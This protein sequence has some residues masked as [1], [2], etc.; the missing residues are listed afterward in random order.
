MKVTTSTL[1]EITGEELAKALGIK[2]RLA[3]L[4]STKTKDKILFT[5]TCEGETSDVQV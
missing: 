1:Y 4:T 2:G 5:F 3:N